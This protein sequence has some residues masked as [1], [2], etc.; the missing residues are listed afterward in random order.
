MIGVTPDEQSRCSVCR[1]SGLRWGWLTVLIALP[2]G[3]VLDLLVELLPFAVILGL[4][5]IGVSFYSSSFIF[6]YWILIGAV[7]AMFV[8]YG[9]KFLAPRCAICGG[10]GKRSV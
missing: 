9:S 6:L 2:I 7:G 10:T 8:W 1:G 5:V 3:L 4:I